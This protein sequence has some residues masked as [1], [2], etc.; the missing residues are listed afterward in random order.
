MKNNPCHHNLIRPDEAIGD[1]RWHWTSNIVRHID[2]QTDI[3]KKESTTSII[4][5]NKLTSYF[6]NNAKIMIS[7]ILKA[8]LLVGGD[9]HFDHPHN[10]IEIG[11]QATPFQKVFSSQRPILFSSIESKMFSAAFSQLETKVLDF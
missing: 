3:H 8:C 1:D 10:P 11:Y 9:N 5:T 6:T 4:T 7:I 2:T